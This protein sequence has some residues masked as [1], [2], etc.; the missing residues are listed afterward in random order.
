MYDYKKQHNAG[1]V[2]PFFFGTFYIEIKDKIESF[3]QIWGKF[4]TNLEDTSLKFNKKN[5]NSLK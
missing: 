4:E 5:N 2:F 1:K 3:K